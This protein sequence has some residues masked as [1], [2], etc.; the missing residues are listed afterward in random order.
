MPN[1][2]TTERW[3]KFAQLVF[4]GMPHVDAFLECGYSPKGTRSTHVRA[5]K[6]MMRY[7]W[8]VNRLEELRQ[9][10]E[11]A[12]ISTVVERKII[13][14]EIE[15]AKISDFVDE[16]GNLHITDKEK[17]RNS[18]VQEIKTERTLAGYRTTL[19]LR[20]PVGAIAE[21]NKMDGVYQPEGTGTTIN[22]NIEKA[23]ITAGEKL[24]SKLTSLAARIP[25]KTDSGQP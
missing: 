19:K 1:G 15:R 10:A 8:V 7:P 21:H 22:I 3:E 16:H 23:L 20:D 14:T 18:A 17:L 5:A 25:E 2:A 9:K 4:L 24:E 12:A 6:R 11:D 13:L